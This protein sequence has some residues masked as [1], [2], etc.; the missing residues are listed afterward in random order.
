MSNK[1]QFSKILKFKPKLAGLRIWF[2]EFVYYL[3]FDA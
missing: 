1:N 3:F 2:L